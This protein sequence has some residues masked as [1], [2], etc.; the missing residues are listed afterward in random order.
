[1]L[2]KRKECL[3]CKTPHNLHE[4]HVFEGCYRQASEKYGLT[5]W[6]CFKHH[7]GDEGIHFNTK[8][9]RQLKAKAQK[10]FE[11][12]YGHEKFMQ[13]FKKNYIGDNNG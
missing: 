1:M 12:I 11:Q 3:I 10:A 2:Q 8:L 4:H 7:T 13:I 9:D 5:V 6:L